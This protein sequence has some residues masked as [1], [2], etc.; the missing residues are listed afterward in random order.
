MPTH[1]KLATIL[2]RKGR[3]ILS[4]APDASVR[5]ALSLMA[6]HLVAAVLVMSEGKLIGIVS[7]RDYGWDV[8]LEGKSSAGVTVREIMSSPVMTVD[9]DADA[10]EGLAIMTGNQ[11]R[12][13]PVFERDKLI[14]VVSMQDLAESII[15][16]QSFAIDQLKRYIG[17]SA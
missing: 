5:E 15:A 12:H 7:A 2:K 14:G 4:V 1:E 6:S 13:L 11:I 3:E 9:A 10:V 16:E 17:T 8:V